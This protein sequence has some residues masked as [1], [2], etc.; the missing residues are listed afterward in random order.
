MGQKQTETVQSFLMKVMNGLGTGTVIVVLPTGLFG[1]LFQALQQQYPIMQQFYT[2]TQMVSSLMGMVSGVI[3]GLLFGFSSLE[4]VSVGLAVIFAGGAV[5]LRDG[6][7]AMQGMGDIIVMAI[8]ASIAVVL[9][10]LV[11]HRLKAYQLLLLP[12]IILFV[13]GGIGALMYPTVSQ[14]TTAIGSAIQYMLNLQPF[15][16]AMLIAAAFALLI[17]SPI[18]SAGV[19]LT[20]GI[21]GLGAGIA[22]VGIS[23]AGIGL[24]LAGRR[25][26][27]IG[28]SIALIIGSPKLALANFLRKPLM[29]LPMLLSAA[30]SGLVGLYLN[31]QGNSMSAGFGLS[32]L[33]GPIT[34]LNLSPTGWSLDQ[35]LVTFIAFFVVPSVSNWVFLYLCRDVWHLVTDEDYRIQPVG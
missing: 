21:T 3:I 28:T 8:T 30:V 14:L 19:A 12:S 13:A 29:F 1:Q 24:A 27:P 18:T 17:I 4:A 11:S 33:L 20:I 22:A 26:N 5:Q 32:G 6:V 10:K 35:L 16:M 2:A 25:V 23:A 31:V 15:V 9:V 7:I 34:H